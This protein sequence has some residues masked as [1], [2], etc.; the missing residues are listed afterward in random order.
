[1]FVKY[2]FA[3]VSAGMIISSAHAQSS[4]TPSDVATKFC[5]VQVL[6]EQYNPPQKILDFNQQVF[7]KFPDLKQLHLRIWGDLNINQGG[8]TPQA[9]ADQI[10]YMSIPNGV[11]LGFHPDNSKSSASTW[12]SCIPYSSNCRK[13]CDS[14]CSKT[15]DNTTQTCPSTC[16]LSQN[17]S[18]CVYQASIQ[19]MNEVNNYLVKQNPPKK[20][21]IFSI[22]QSYIETAPI[23]PPMNPNDGG[24]TQADQLSNAI[25]HQKQCLTGNVQA[26]NPWCP[27]GVVS[28]QAVSYA[29]VGPSCMAANLFGPLFF[30]YGYPQMYNLYPPY[31]PSSASNHIY[32]LPQQYVPSPFPPPPTT[33][34]YQVWDANL[35]PNNPPNPPVS[36]VPAYLNLPRTSSGYSIYSPPP[37]LQPPQGTQTALTLISQILA[38]MITTKYDLTKM[39]R[40]YPCVDTTNSTPQPYQVPIY[41]TISGEPYM[42]GNQTMFTSILSINSTLSWVYGYV[43]SVKVAGSPDIPQWPLAIWSFDTMPQINPPQPKSHRR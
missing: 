43:N 30:D 2:F 31:T 21:T 24:D 22:E 1:M 32:P 18:A 12:S 40:T 28:A 14:S 37:G 23:L 26:G 35:T 39:A 4:C 11:E 13:A 8:G 16:D 34:P 17:P 25:K 41:F 15:C 27:N 29:E 10:N 5:N 7:P 33:P 6:I 9:I 19:F 20:F 3:L 38:N 42:W 36:I